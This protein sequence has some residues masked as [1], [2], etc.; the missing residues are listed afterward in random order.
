ML[1]NLVVFLCVTGPPASSIVRLREGSIQAEGRVEVRI[2][3][4]WPWGA[5]CDENWSLAD[6]EVVCQQL[7]YSRALRSTQH[8]YFSP[9]NG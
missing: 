2:N 5:V 9:S 7:G 3:N 1:T 6:A 4:Q 8:S